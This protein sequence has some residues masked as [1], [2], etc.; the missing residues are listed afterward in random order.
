MDRL[1]IVESNGDVRLHSIGVNLRKI[2]RVSAQARG[3]I[4]GADERF[5]LKLIDESGS[6]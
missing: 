1:F 2:R 4:Q 5:F 3:N 6:L